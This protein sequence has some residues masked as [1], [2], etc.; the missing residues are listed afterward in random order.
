MYL[1]VQTFLVLLE[2][3]TSHKARNP[4]AERI[5]ILC[6]ILKHLNILALKKIKQHTR[7]ETR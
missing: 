2:S 6:K 4:F 7:F 3:I 1:F 5:N